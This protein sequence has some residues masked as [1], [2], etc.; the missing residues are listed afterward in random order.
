MPTPWESIVKTVLVGTERHPLSA[1]T[2]AALGLPV[3]AEPAQAALEALAIA[4]LRR[5]AGFLLA[6]APAER[7]LPA[8]HDPRPIC[9]PAAVA[10]F[11]QMLQGRH[12]S[13]LPEF[14]DLLVTSGQR[15]PPELLPELLQTGLDNRA[16]FAQLEPALG[17]VGHWLARQH[18]RWQALLTDAQAD[19]FTASFAERQRLLLAARRRRPL[20]GL[21]W[22][23]ATWKQDTSGQQAKFL[24]SFVCG[25]SPHDEP[26]LQQAATDRN[27]A[28]RTVARRLLHLLSLSPAEQLRLATA[29]RPEDLPANVQRDLW[30]EAARFALLS[31]SLFSPKML[32]GAWPEL[33]GQMV[34]QD[35]PILTDH[36]EQVAKVIC[37]QGDLATLEAALAA[38]TSQIPPAPRQIFADI[39]DFRR[40]MVAAF[41]NAL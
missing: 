24:E 37:Y 5:K 41:G 14:L 12:R 4:H 30:P 15:L 19:W 9:G 6:D 17:P 16:L 36:F 1:A 29:V 38:Q 40:Q 26:L 23:E 2:L 13:A 22:L 21:A 10:L 34:H 20:V 32:A 11:R 27:E 35:F 39:L 28:V 18:L 25:L 3:A 7:P 33:L 31:R 8:P